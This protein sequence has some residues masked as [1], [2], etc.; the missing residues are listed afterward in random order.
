MKVQACVRSIEFLRNRAR[1]IRWTKR[2]NN[3]CDKKKLAKIAIE[4]VFSNHDAI[5]GGCTAPVSAGQI[6]AELTGIFLYH[7]IV[8]YQDPSGNE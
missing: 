7:Y 2:Q 3:E 5:I 4:S 1:I 6:I 8:L